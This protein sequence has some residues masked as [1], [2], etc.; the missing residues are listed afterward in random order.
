MRIKASMNG[1]G[2]IRCYLTYELVRNGQERLPTMRSYRTF[3]AIEVF[4]TTIT[5]TCAASAA[6]FMVKS[7]RFTGEIGDVEWLHDDVLKH[8]R[9][10]NGS[11]FR[12]NIGG[13]VLRLDVDFQPDKRAKIKVV[14]RETDEHYN[15]GPVFHRANNFA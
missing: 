7:R 8:H 14:L 12:C 1:L 13:Q 2:K 9:V 3:L 10:K 4:S 15:Y 5:R 11:S 6:V